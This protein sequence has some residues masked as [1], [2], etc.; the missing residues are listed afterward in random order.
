MNNITLKFSALFLIFIG[1]IYFFVAHF[2]AEK[3]IPQAHENTIQNHEEVVQWAQEHLPHTGV[4]EEDHQ[5]FVYL[6]V[7]D[8]YINKLYPLLKHR[9]YTK[10]DYFRRPNAPGAH[11]SVFYIDERYRTGKIHEIGQTIP[12]TIKSLDIVPP[13]SHQYIVL[14]IEAPELEALRKKYGLKPLLKGHDF[15]ITIA[16]KKHHVKHHHNQ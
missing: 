13:T 10:P 16:K 4:L 7:D 5:G 8:D 9:G 6:K 3:P 11:V 12:F 15:H 2:T 14:Q 1:V